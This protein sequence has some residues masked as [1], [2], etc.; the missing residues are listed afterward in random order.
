MIVWHLTENRGTVV[1]AL[2]AYDF[3]VTL[4]LQITLGSRED[5]GETVIREEGTIQVKDEKKSNKR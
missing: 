2:G 1:C 4:S 3:F 5:K